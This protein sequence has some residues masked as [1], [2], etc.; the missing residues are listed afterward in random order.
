MGVKHKIRTPEGS[1]IEVVLTPTRA[2][3]CFCTACLGWEGNPSQCTGKNCELYP[4]RGKSLAY[5]GKR[6]HELTDEQKVIITE[7]LRIAR[8]KKDRLEDEKDERKQ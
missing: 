3:K 2:I 5:K 1:L 7:R 4:F 8:E 6:E